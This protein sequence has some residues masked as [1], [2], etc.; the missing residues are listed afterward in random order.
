[1][2]RLG[3]TVVAGIVLFAGVVIGAFTWMHARS[4]P[5]EGGMATTTPSVNPATLSIYTSGEFGFSFFY[6]SG[7]RVTDAYSTSTLA[8]MNWRVGA[9]GTG[10]PVVKVEES[11]EELRVGLSTD[12][13]EVR[14]CSQ[15]GPSEESMGAFTQGSTT[16]QRY[17]FK[18]LGT[19]DEH[20]V[21]SYRTVHEDACYAVE[22][23]V[24][25]E[26]EAT[27]T[28]YTLHDAMNNFSFAP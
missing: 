14:A 22:L 10:T 7:A 16:W 27:S 9:T 13:R 3:W 17:T 19:D 26:G 4:A 28:G 8:S 12:A 11:N 20:Q 5:E 2:T 6:P 23:F 15:K 21:T 1:M 24:P 25:L 18:K